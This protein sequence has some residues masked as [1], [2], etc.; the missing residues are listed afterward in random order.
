MLYE[1]NDV[2][3]YIIVIINGSNYYFQTR[4]SCPHSGDLSLTGITENEKRK[5]SMIFDKKNI[6]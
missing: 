2:T 3:A 4:H 5:S 1:K 6:G